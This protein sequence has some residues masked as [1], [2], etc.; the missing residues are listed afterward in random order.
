[1][2][3]HLHL[4]EIF[5]SCTA[6]PRV[7][8]RLSLS[9]FLPPS[10]G[11][12]CNKFNFITRLFMTCRERFKVRA[13]PLKIAICIA[14]RPRASRYDASSCFWSGAGEVRE[15]EFAPSGRRAAG[16]LRSIGDERLAYHRTYTRKIYIR[17]NVK[18]VFIL[19]L[20]AKICRLNL[21][22]YSRAVLFKK[23]YFLTK[24][25]K[26]EKF[27]FFLHRSNMGSLNFP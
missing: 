14:M 9:L 3:P 24:L 22:K 12:G 25:E 19:F 16:N 2:R 26:K 20:E 27:I 15:K 21:D 8:K 5:Y 6:S 13:V 1:M 4:P 18:N 23:K 17:I 7:Q 10:A 11:S